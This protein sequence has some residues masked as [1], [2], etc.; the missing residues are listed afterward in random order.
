MGMTHPTVRYTI[1]LMNH[2]GTIRFGAAL[3]RW[4]GMLPSARGCGRDGG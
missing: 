4:N 2:D 1:L 3:R